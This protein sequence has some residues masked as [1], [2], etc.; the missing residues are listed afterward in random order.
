MSYIFDSF[1][2][3]QAAGTF[4]ATIVAIYPSRSATVCASQDVSDMID[5]FPYRVT[6][7]IVL[8]SRD[9]DDGPAIEGWME[10]QAVELGGHFVGT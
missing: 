5:P 2:T 7:L 4:A 10:R 9:A 1:P 8:V 6:P 3:A